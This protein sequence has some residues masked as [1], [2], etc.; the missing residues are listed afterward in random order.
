MGHIYFVD[1][2]LSRIRRVSRD[3]VVT[4]MAGSDI[5]F[6][7]SSG[8]KSQFRDPRYVLFLGNKT[9]MVVDSGNHRIRKITLP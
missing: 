9:L 1:F 5:G 3:G 2:N 8:T 7:D 4:T 6:A